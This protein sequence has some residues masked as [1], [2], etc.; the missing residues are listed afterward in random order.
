MGDTV[1][2]TSPEGER[3]DVPQADVPTYLGRRFTVETP[4]QQL[5]AVRS[6]IR[7]KEYGGAAG[8][9]ATAGISALGTA[10][11]GASDAGLSALG[12]DEAAD[13]LR[14]VNPTS[15]TIGTVGGA[16]IPFAGQLAGAARLGKAAAIGEDALTAERAAS[17]LSS[18]FLLGG[19]TTG[20]VGSVERG[21]GRA[22]K[23]LDSSAVAGDAA[24]AAPDL[25][26]LDIKGLDAAHETEVGELATQQGAARAKAVGDA[27]A[28]RQAVRE[29]NPWLVI[30]EGEGSAALTK[31]NKTLRAALDD[32]RGLAENPRSLLK[33]LRQ[34]EDALAAAL[35]D[36]TAITAKLSE[37][38]SKL[39][40]GLEQDLAESGPFVKEL[41][42]SGK[43]AKRY[44]SYAGVK[45]GKGAV[46]VARDDAQGFLEAL[47]G[48]QVSGQSEEAL[49]K[50]PE[51]LERNRALQ[52]SITESL[53]PKAELTSPRL[54]AIKDAKAALQMPL[55][56]KSLPQQMLEGHVFGAATAL[57]SPLGH[58]APVIG[59]KASKLVGDLV[60]GK[61]GKDVAATAARTAE[62][63]KAFLGTAA[64]SPL[65]PVL[66]TR[67][68]AN[69]AFGPRDPKAPQPTDLA[70]L[71][72]ARSAELRAQTAYDETG[73]P[74]IRP[75]A[76]QA[77]AKQLA[78]IGMVS[79]VL[80]DKM[81]TTAVARIEW[82]A[83][84]LPRRPDI[85]GIPI[86]GPDR[87]KP[88]EL[89][90]RSF[91]RKVAAAEHPEGV[92]HRLAHGTITPED[93]AAY[94][95][96]YPERAAQL[97]QMVLEQLPDLKQ[98]LPYRNR[99]ALSMFTGIAVDP[100][101]EP[102]I[103]RV[104]QGNFAAEP[105][106]N[107]GTSQPT[108]TPNPSFGSLRKSVEQ[109]TPVQQQAAGR[110]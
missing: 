45:V 11:F 88:S 54:Q 86:G 9:L 93:V 82:L 79:P 43:T 109:P 23:A 76:R 8:K 96:V 103:L 21:L 90:M 105:N 48:G 97:K 27:T 35:E 3:V 108:V 85:G 84:Q 1:T 68:L 67:V 31:S 71:Y 55:A 91:A 26:G 32:P 110:S 20:G 63:A 40:A 78:P 14:A 65:V 17:G 104:L 10:T 33:P 74:R 58:F 41:E 102:R 59:A 39:A 72:H 99:L 53:V 12:I 38:N 70:G 52:E 95:A 98:A 75:E 81:E 100:A 87:W 47:K 62:N 24:R 69:A 34:Q 64:K 56:P 7:E 107:G 44:G 83:S 18:K 106:T 4:D 22:G 89:D 25:A 6:N 42:L 46:T 2:L 16:I 94:H 57:A 73:T 28:Y 19:E 51:L 61:L 92:E 5:S 29:A 36:R 101:L 60:F 77:I 13:T 15:S 50:L 66:A 30:D 49:G 37:T 80:A